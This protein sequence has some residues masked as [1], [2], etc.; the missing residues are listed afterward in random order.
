MSTLVSK[1]SQYRNLPTIFFF[2]SFFPKNGPLSFV[3]EKPAVFYLKKTAFFLFQ[4]DSGF[5]KSQLI[6]AV[7]FGSCFVSIGIRSTQEQS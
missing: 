2:F 7:A 5:L 6:K 3:K 1:Y 4:V